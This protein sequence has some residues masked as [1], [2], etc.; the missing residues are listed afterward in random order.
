MGKRQIRRL[1]SKFERQGTYSK[2]SKGLLKKA[3][4]IA[5]LCDI[6][7]ALIMYSPTETLRHFST[8]PNVERVLQR[9]VQH[10]P[11]IPEKERKKFQVSEE[12]IN[13]INFA[14]DQQGMLGPD[15]AE[16]EENN[17]E[18]R[19]PR[20]KLMLLQEQERMLYPGM[21]TLNSMP[22]FEER[23]RYL[24]TYLYKIIERE[25]LLML[26]KQQEVAESLN[27]GPSQRGGQQVQQLGILVDGM[28]NPVSLNPT[29]SSVQ[30]AVAGSYGNSDFQQQ[31]PMQQLFERT[32]D[33]T[34]VPLHVGDRMH[35]I[36]RGMAV[37]DSAQT[38]ESV[39][40]FVTRDQS[41]D[42]YVYDAFWAKFIQE[43]E[44]VEPL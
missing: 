11:S 9:F 43:L 41:G 34:Q 8:A 23:K 15:V 36:Q 40:P 13:W 10:L 2:R 44:P 14:A 4:E 24:E 25:Q 22:A 39:P 29:S 30:P 27:W 6:E 31:L 20:N 5:A 18:I 1:E 19:D 3:Y 21:G 37:V 38:T 16:E 12:T 28:G 33:N 17:E 32:S 26:K 42:Q 7:A 35:E